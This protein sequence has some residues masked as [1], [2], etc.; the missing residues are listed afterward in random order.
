MPKK[1]YESEKK[2]IL[3]SFVSGFEIKEIAK[4]YN[5]S[6][7]TISRQLR[8]LLSKN[9]FENIK[10]KN[11]KA[12]K[13][14]SFDSSKLENIQDNN[15]QNKI[16]S[17]ENLENNIFEVVPILNE[18][19]LYKQKELSSEPFSEAELPEV[20][21]LIV[22]KNIELVPKLLKD[23]PEW[24][25]LPEEDLKRM[26]LKIFADQRNAKKSCSKN[27]KSLKIPNSKVF[28]TASNS[29]KSKGITRVI[30]D[31]LLLSL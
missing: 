18:I 19:D 16:D 23:Y 30:F 20:V 1:V 22:D 13:T 17:I 31:D 8:K 26:T 25:Y 3:D 6:S 2:S 21:Y 15:D 7:A 9:D 14:T 29:L 4:N 10:E 27:Q 5:Y 24:G 11:S 12:H 28:I